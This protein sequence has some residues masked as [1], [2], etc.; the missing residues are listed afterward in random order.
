MS[1]R[2]EATLE[3]LRPLF[4]GP[5]G[6]L[7]WPR[8][9]RDTRHGMAWHR[10]PHLVHFDLHL[11]LP[12]FLPFFLSLLFFPCFGTLG[13]LDHLHWAWEILFLFVKG[14]RHAPGAAYVDTW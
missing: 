2:R 13:I 3:E 6:Q 11:F 14:P 9:T 4:L 5:F 1:D 8:D 7:D 10:L 12:P